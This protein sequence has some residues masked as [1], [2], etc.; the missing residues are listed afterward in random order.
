MSKI[1][2][3]NKFE[4]PYLQTKNIENISMSNLESIFWVCKGP[5][6]PSILALI[7]TTSFLKVLQRHI[8]QLFLDLK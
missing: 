3:I 2:R 8:I 5:R 6:R 7:L 4:G 1:R